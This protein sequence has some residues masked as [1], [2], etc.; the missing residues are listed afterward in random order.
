MCRRTNLLDESYLGFIYDVMDK[1]GNLG[2]F[3]VR[4]GQILNIL[5]YK[6]GNVRFTIRF[7]H[8]TSKI[9]RRLNA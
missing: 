8:F 9:V 5:L 3:S 1:D 2:L 4:A 7:Y 6:I